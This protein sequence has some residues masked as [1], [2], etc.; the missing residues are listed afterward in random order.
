MD[1]LL[2]LLGFAIAASVTP[3]PNTLMVTAA[4]A[5]HGVRAT[6]PHMLGITLGF[7]AMLLIVGLGLAAPFA[8]WPALHAALK[9]VGGAWLLVIA[10]RI[11]RA[12]APGE[13]PARPPLGFLGAALFQWV[14][15]K[16]WMIALAAI[17]AFTTP[18]GDTLAETLLIS[19]TFA[20]VC[21]PCTALWA[22]LGAGARRLLGTPSRLRAFNLAM[23]VLMVASLLPAFL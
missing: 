14:N 21:L 19:A 2:P 15:P 13:G 9:W 8:A 18:E 16:A 23:A 20:A 5:N 3:G 22:G 1:T 7:A 17:P 12:G 4:A 11:A 10:W 6:L